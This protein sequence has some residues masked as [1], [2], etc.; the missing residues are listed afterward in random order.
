VSVRS[1]PALGIG[2]PTMKKKT[3]WFDWFV[4]GSFWLMGII[5]AFGMIVI[6]LG[7]D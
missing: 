7:K 2:D 5:M 4:T 3:S 1:K 6:A